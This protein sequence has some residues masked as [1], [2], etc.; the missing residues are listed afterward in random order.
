MLLA[1][2]AEVEILTDAAVPSRS[3]RDE[4]ATLVMT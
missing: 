4:L 1:L 3:P 2:V